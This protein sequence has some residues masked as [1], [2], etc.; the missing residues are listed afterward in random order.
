MSE[1]LTLFKRV[2]KLGRAS[3]L[4]HKTLF[5]FTSTYEP[6]LFSRL[7]RF[8]LNCEPM[9]HMRAEFYTHHR[10]RQEEQRFCVLWK[11]SSGGGREGMAAALEQNSSCRVQNSRTHAEKMTFYHMSETHTH[12]HTRLPGYWRTPMGF[13]CSLIKDEECFFMLT[14]FLMPV[15]YEGIH[16]LKSTFKTLFCLLE[17]PAQQQ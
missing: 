6:L 12:T 13:Y 15:Y 9:S 7:G 14:Y 1:T 3:A 2:E 4:L 5:L 8:P 16:L 11:P 17:Q 10:V